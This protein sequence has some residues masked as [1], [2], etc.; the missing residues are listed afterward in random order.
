MVGME[1]EDAVHR[2]RQHRID[3]VL[4]A[5]HR[6]AHAQEVRGV[7][8]VVLRIDEGLTDRILV[9]HRCERRHL[10]DHADRRDVA[11]D[12]IGDVGG[13]VVE[14][15]ERADRADHH[16]HRMG[17]A[18]EP[19]EEPAHLLVNHGV[20]G[21]DVVEFRLLGR[22][23]QL[24]VE[25]EVAGLEKVAV[26]GELLDRIAAIEQDAFVAVDI[27]DL[28]FAARRRGEAGVVGEDAGVGVE[29]G[30]VDH[31]GT[32]GAFVDRELVV[33]VA[34]GQGAVL[35]VRT[36]RRVHA[37]VLEFDCAAMRCRTGVLGDVIKL[38]APPG[39]RITSFPLTC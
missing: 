4:L 12:R 30:D 1:D 5:R 19:L 13:V 8:E 25:Q 24:A 14:R 38:S 27:G 29:L 33:F 39:A 35:G 22:G 26:L 11:L 34:E 2:P 23:R 18:P 3:L 7:V 10:R 37:H 20:A 28:G 17:V 31:L 9:G 16:C 15:G 21:H 6:V 32:D 36:G